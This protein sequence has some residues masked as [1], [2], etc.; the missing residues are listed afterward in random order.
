MQPAC[1]AIRARDPCRRM[2]NG[3]SLPPPRRALIGR[4][5]LRLDQSRFPR[6][7]EL[8]METYTKSTPINS[9]AIRSTLEVTREAP[10]GPFEGSSTVV[11][12]LKAPPSNVCLSGSFI[13][14]HP[15]FYQLVV[16]Y[17][18]KQKWCSHRSGCPHSFPRCL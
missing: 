18:P 11:C 13:S 12:R 10:P 4:H 6:L 17:M 7:G 3:R 9:L 5:L 1:I 14:L 8:G 16:W 15:I 2:P